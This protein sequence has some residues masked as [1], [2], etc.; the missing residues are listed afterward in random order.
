MTFCIAFHSY[1]GGTGKT[2]IASNLSAYLANR[3]NIVVLLDMDLYSPSLHTY[4]RIDSKKWINDFLYS[5]TN[6]NIKD[7]IVELPLFSPIDK[8]E[9]TN[10]LKQSGQEST[11]HG[12]QQDKKNGKLF[13]GLAL[14]K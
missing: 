14:M 3:G 1:K 12:L 7:I 2:T 5:S 4:F 13:L 6:V 8:N 11:N 9:K 10:I